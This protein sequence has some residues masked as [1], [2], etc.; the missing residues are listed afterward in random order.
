[1]ID[2]FDLRLRF[3]GDRLVMEAK[4]RTYE[5]GVTLEGRAE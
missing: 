4:D 3:E 1:M 5:Q 2:A